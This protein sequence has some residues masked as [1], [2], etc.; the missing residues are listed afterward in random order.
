M[1]RV[2]LDT[3]V[4]VPGRVH[5]GRSKLLIDEAVDGKIELVVS[6]QMLDEFKMVIARDKFKLSRSQQRR[7]ANFVLRLSK[8]VEVRSRFRAIPADPS[9]DAVL[10]AAYDGAVEYIVSGDAHLLALKRYRGIKII[11]VGEMLDLLKQSEPA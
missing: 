1:I 10:R 2:V 8:L 3:N 11:T 4:L 9:D 5:A 7:V 6:A